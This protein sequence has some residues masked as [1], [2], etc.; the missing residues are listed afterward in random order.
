MARR[1][2]TRIEQTPEQKAAAELERRRES[3]RKALTNGIT[4]EQ[5]T[6]KVGT[7]IEQAAIRGAKPI[8]GSYDGRLSV[9]RG[10]GL[11]VDLYVTI[12]QD[13]SSRVVNPDDKDE[14]V[15]FHNVR[16]EITWSST[17]RSVAKAHAAVTLYAEVVA[18]AAEIEAV[19]A[20]DPIRGFWSLKPE[21][22]P[23][24]PGPA[25][26]DQ[27]GGCNRYAEP[28]ET[29]ATV[30]VEEAES[31]RMGETHPESRCP[32]CVQAKR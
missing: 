4:R 25:Q 5:A 19:L 27:C 11:G 31:H 2:V 3:Y 21:P 9:E 15:F 14:C 17:G 30:E 10:W 26:P 8:Y 1:T 6:A 12:G 29:F 18:L 23:E 28:G 20:E 24:Q 16:V 13:Y 22:E 32:A 7:I